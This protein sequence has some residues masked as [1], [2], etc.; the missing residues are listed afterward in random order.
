MFSI[1]K[2][3]VKAAD[4]SLFGVWLSALLCML[5]LA[6]QQ[7]HEGFHCGRV[8][9]G[10]SLNSTVKRAAS[11]Q[12]IHSKA[13]LLFQWMYSFEPHISILNGLAGRQVTHGTGSQIPSMVTVSPSYPDPSTNGI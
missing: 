3:R 10:F 2:I 9:C 8:M 12:E 13:N 1:Y 4:G 7:K 6:K 5:E 11:L